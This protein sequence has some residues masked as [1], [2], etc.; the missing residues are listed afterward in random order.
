MTKRFL[1][2][3]DYNSI[4]YILNGGFKMLTTKQVLMKT[5]LLSVTA[6]SFLGAYAYFLDGGF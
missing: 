3:F 6:W 2:L 1:S 5:F 4:T